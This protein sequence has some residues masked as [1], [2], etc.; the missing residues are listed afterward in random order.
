MTLPP[1][2][3]PYIPP[4]Q[5][6]SR[7]SAPAINRASTTPRELSLALPG[8][9]EVLPIVYG[10]DR[11]AGLWL[12]RPY[13][14]SSQLRF[15]IAWCWG[16]I[17]GVQSVYINGAAV[18]GGVTMTHYA[19]TDTQTPNSLLATNLPGFNDAYANIAYTVFQ[20]P[21]GAITGF[22]NTAQIEAV[23]RGRIVRDPRP[24]SVG[25][26]TARYWRVLISETR[27]TSSFFFAAI[28]EI[29]MR[30][31]AGG[32][33]QTGSGT[34][35]ASSEVSNTAADQAFDNSPSTRWA[36]GDSQPAPQWIAY[37]FGSAVSVAQITIQSGDNAIR[38]ARAPRSFEVQYSDDGADW[39]T[40]TSFTDESAWAV[41]EVRAYSVV[42]GPLWSQNPA[43]CMAD[44]IQSTRYGP[45]LPA[46]GVGACADRCDEIVAGAEVRC[47]MGLTI[48]NPMP[49]DQML[50]LFSAYAECLWSYDGDGI[51]MVPDAPV[52]APDATLTEADIIAGTL[53]L[54]AEDSSSAPTAVSMTYRVPGATAA[55]QWEEKVHVQMLPGVSVGDVPAVRSDLQMLGLRRQT[56][57]ARKAIMRLRRLNYPGRY[58]WQAFD[59]GIKFRRG[60]VVQLPN[61]RGMTDRMVRILSTEMPSPGIYQVTAEQYDANMYSD[62][63]TPGDTAQVPVGGLL[64]FSGAVAPDGYEIFSDADGRYIVGAGGAYSD[65][66]TGGSSVI[67]GWSGS[68]SGGGH[69]GSRNMLIWGNRG[70]NPG[71]DIPYSQFTPPYVGDHT[72][73][74]TV[75]DSAPLN[76][77]GR[78]SVWIKK[79]GAPGP[80]PEGGEVLSD[81][82]LIS[83]ALAAVSSFLGRIIMAD[84]IN[85]N[86]GSNSA[87]AVASIVSASDSHTHSGQMY[88]RVMTG[89]ISGAFEYTFEY[90]SGG[91]SHNHGGAAT[92]TYTPNVR[93]RRL[94]V[95]MATKDSPIQPGCVIGFDPSEVLPPGWSVC[96]GTDGTV[97]LRGF[98]VERSSVGAAG[99]SGGNNTAQYFATTAS[100]MGHNHV[101]DS[102]G[103]YQ[104]YTEWWHADSVSHNHSLSG[105][106]PFIP[107]YYAMTF[108]QYTGVE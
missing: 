21:T 45:G 14:A 11:I 107:P 13:V 42:P 94:A 1:R 35:L 70:P 73:A 38:A 93:R 87:S 24:P 101:G 89:P 99:T 61:M 17:E 56:E 30:A 47:E 71:F 108:I 18:P 64:P 88:E 74:C 82:E 59:D 51:L 19:G 97:D 40:A 4:R 63:Y 84:D 66:S 16:E 65:G 95:Y 83:S 12:V 75:A 79:T 98:F 102:R 39:N 72:H 53:R 37:D 91:G 20:V 32:A 55:A 49:L 22:P 9:D 29:E 27:T 52:T 44:F 103:Y 86:Y 46:Y 69:S 36:S 6:L 96:D 68:V 23:L 2:L 85:A 62:D 78:K 67:P 106:R 92:G 28:A 10:E 100:D 50:D 54:T 5:T 25:P 26:V 105:T 15:A 60:D 43:L 58:A 31:T 8:F 90:V 81:G 77:S 3:P 57:A 41:S 80:V 33:D 48:K 104:P 76:P 34:A 7:P